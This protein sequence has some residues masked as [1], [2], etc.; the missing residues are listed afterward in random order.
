MELKKLVSICT[1]KKSLL[2]FI[3]PD[4]NINF[5]PNC[6]YFL[7]NKKLDL[8]QVSNLNFNLKKINFSD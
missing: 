7:N 6:K 1:N 8:S 2:N 5:D 3:F 4:G